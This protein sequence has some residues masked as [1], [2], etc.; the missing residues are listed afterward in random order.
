[1]P[2]NGIDVHDKKGIVDWQRVADDGNAF[3]FIRAA[4]GERTDMLVAQNFPKAKAQGLICGL[5][6]FYRVTRNPK[7]QADIMVMTMRNVGFGPGD[8]PPVID[9][10]D[11]PQFDGDWD[12]ANNVVFIQGIR[13]WIDRIRQEFNCPSII[14]TRAS[15]WKL[16]G[17]PAGFG[18]LPLW[19][20]H[21]KNAQG[22]PTTPKLPTGWTD[23]A[24]WQYS[25]KGK[26][27]GVNGNCDVNLFPGTPAQLRALTV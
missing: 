21:Y 12:T 8:L 6:H 20:A 16:I 26:V 4:Y 14:Y 7:K 5:Y 13:D 10:E 17:E 24:F 18:T 3:A 2:L 23:Y 25:E 1:M 19:V 27:D 22:N 9:V 15:F 11:N